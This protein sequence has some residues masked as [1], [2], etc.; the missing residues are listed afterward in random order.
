MQN[1]QD[2]PVTPRPEETPTL[3]AGMRRQTR[4]SL[5]DEGSATSW[6]VGARLG[7]ILVR[8]RLAVGGIGEVFEGFDESLRRSVALKALRHDRFDPSAR[9]RLLREARV[10]SQLSDARICAIHGW[11]ED[12]RGDFLVLELIEGATLAGAQLSRQEA[13]RLA[14]DLA[15]VLDASHR[16]GIV[17]RDIKPQNLMCTHTGRLKVLDFGLSSIAHASV[18][19]SDAV[20]G[21]ARF[22]T[23][24][25]GLIGT[26]EY[27]SPEQANGEAATA[28]SDMYSF[29]LVLAELLCGRGP[30]Q[31]IEDEAE[32]LARSRRGEHQDLGDLPPALRDLIE[33]L[34]AVAPEARPTAAATVELLVAIRE[35]PRRRLRQLAVGGL[36]VLAAGAGLWHTQQLTH[37]RNRALAA[38]ASA[39]AA[40]REAE[41]VVDFLES[42]FEVAGPQRT[43]GQAV[44]AREILERGAARIATELS[45]QPAVRARLMATMG[46]VAR[47]VGLFAEADTLLTEALAIDRVEQGNTSSEVVLALL[48]LGELRLNQDRNADADGAFSEAVAIAEALEGPDGPLVARALLQLGGAASQAGEHDR[49]DQLLGR[50]LAIVER[51]AGPSSP[52]IRVPLTER[53]H[54]HRR[55]GQY[56]EAVALYQRLIE[57]ENV[58]PTTLLNAGTVRYNLGISLSQLGRFG[59]A[60]PVL[61]AARTAWTEAFGEANHEV[62]KVELALATVDRRSGRFAEAE[63]RYRAAITIWETTYGPDSV[64]VAYGFN[65][66]ANLHLETGKV[67]AAVPYFRQAM[68]IFETRSGANHPNVAMAAAN[69]GRALASLGQ[70]GEAETLLRRAVAIDEATG[71]PTSTDLG[72]DTVAL[73]Q[74][75][76][77]A[78]ANDPEA[79]ELLARG[80]TILDAAVGRDHPELVDLL[81]ETPELV[82]SLPKS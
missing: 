28:A 68:A 75:L 63:Q 82:A 34:T 24:A 9:A 18:A 40:Q 1:S 44:T 26:L 3:D 16:L 59:D 20:S 77:H 79:R 60:E 4:P 37:E 62:A 39:Q 65:N 48:R 7:N 52:Q 10:L 2:G 71:G 70:Q 80:L 50:A 19:V 27:M 46:T 73:A 51:T 64:N 13:L 81:A 12:S 14:I 69:L 56:E 31:G 49:A 30:H 36:L 11:H 42:L 58:A 22:T 74:I 45:D 54:A 25:G 33:R 17:H 76:W 32:I 35:A 43:A 15:E 61:Q 41:E 53:A 72:W 66:L 21:G 29:G 55:R 67:E 47:Q 5:S 38:Q 23:R 78:D 6:P 57:L 8:R